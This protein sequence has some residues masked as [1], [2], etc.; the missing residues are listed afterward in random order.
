[1]LI[2]IILLFSGCMCTS[3]AAE[4]S[5]G[6]LHTGDKPVISNHL[7]HEVS[8]EIPHE[9]HHDL[10]DEPPQETP[11]ISSQETTPAPSQISSQETMPASSPI[12]SR[13][14]SLEVPAISSEPLPAVS[15]DI[16]HASSIEETAESE[17]S[18]TPLHV[19]HFEPT[20]ELVQ[21]AWTEEIYESRKN[22][23]IQCRT[24]RTEFRAADYEDAVLVSGTYY[25]LS[26]EQDFLENH[27]ST[28]HNP[29]HRYDAYERSVTIRTQVIEHAAQY[30]TVGICSCGARDE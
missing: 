24:C 16:Q 20:L 23:V 6:L 3:D 28:E 12:A 11:R 10:S 2:G 18:E 17:G 15:S 5:R 27:C 14:L 8:H 4:S 22:A 21:D 29:N 9:I 30:R 25:S 13:D 19:H 1:M 7:L 26:A